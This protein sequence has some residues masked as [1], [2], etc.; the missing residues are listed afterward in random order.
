MI[1]LE[2]TKDQN[3]THTYTKIKINIIEALM[4]NIMW[5]DLK[6]NSTVLL[7]MKQSNTQTSR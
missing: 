3:Q 1:D 5:N 7:P 6:R 2:E 4:N